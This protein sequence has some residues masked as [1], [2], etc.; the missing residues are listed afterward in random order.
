MN[1]KECEQENIDYELAIIDSDVL[2]YELGAITTDHPFIPGQ[3]TPANPAF[4]YQRIED[5]IDR[6]KNITGCSKI[7]FI[8]SGSGN[9]RFDIAKIQP[10]K[11]N[12]NG[13]EKPHHWQTVNDY[14][15]EKYQHVI[16]DGRE[17][18]DWLA[19]YQ[20]VNKNTI[21]CTRDKDL[22]VTPG[23]HYRWA[24]G[25]RQAEVPPHY[26]T[27]IDAW[28]NFFYQMLIGDNTDHIIGCGEKRPVMRGGKE[29]MWRHGVGPK[30]AHKLIDGCTTVTGL[31]HTVR[32][33][34]LRLFPETW[35]CNMLENA[36]LLF[37]GQRPDNLFDWS[38]LDKNW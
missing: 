10:Y 7:L 8:F 3:R 23:W 31:Y 13:L 14:I 2:R 30:A 27:K 26:I 33:E 9:F 15:K 18:D 19:E 12:R 11:G 35:E 21:I 25:D 6:I 38:W 32:I 16:V 37:V 22:L 17:A 28:R 34:Y 24:C 5:K 4:I 20:R 36:R 1:M 29:V